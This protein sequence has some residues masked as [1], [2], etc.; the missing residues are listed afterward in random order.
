FMPASA[1]L[2]ALTICSSV[3]PL[4]RMSPI[5]HG[6]AHVSPGPLSGGKVKAETRPGAAARRVRVPS[7]GGS[8]AWAPSSGV[9][10]GWARTAAPFPPAPRWRPKE[11][12]HSYQL[13]GQLDLVTVGFSYEVPARTRQW[14]TKRRRTRLN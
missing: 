8:F 1:C 11:A 5:L 9:A 12:R 10:A 6:W 14:R 4:F 3:Y 13:F 7:R 2:S